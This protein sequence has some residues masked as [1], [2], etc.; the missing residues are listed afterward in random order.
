M[1]KSKKEY[2]RGEMVAFRLKINRGVA[3]EVPMFSPRLQNFFPSMEKKSSRS[4]PKAGK[5][6]KISKKVTIITDAF[7]ITKTPSL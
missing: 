2:G 4:D 1:P 7:F 5:T 6:E 3:K